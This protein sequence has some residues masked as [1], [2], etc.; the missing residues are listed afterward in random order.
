MA[1][2]RARALSTAV[3]KYKI[4]PTPEQRRAADPQDSV[5][6]AA[7]AGS[8]KTHVLVDR[9]IRLLLDGAAPDAILCLTFT[10]AAAAEMSNRLFQRLSGWVALDDQALTLTLNTLG[11]AHVTEEVRA[12][13]RRLFALALETPGGLKIQTIH[14]FCE[15]LLQAFPVESGLAP[16]FRVMDSQVTADLFRQAL[17]AQLGENTAF[18][19]AL[20]LTIPQVFWCNSP[21][22][23]TL[24]LTLIRNCQFSRLLQNT[25][26]AF[27]LVSNCDTFG[28]RLSV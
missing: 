19:D 17:L 25:S 4:E 15:R 1:I 2:A 14:A 10:K 20:C 27:G 11:V 28:L 12:R 22:V 24:M 16:G 26:R 7:S 18:A 6:V 21:S 23:I 5:W 13:A 9:V 3:I 8:G